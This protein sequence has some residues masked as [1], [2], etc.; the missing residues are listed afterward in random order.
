MINKLK[1]FQSVT[2]KRSPI[3]NFSE[4]YIWKLLTLTSLPKSLISRTARNLRELTSSIPSGETTLRWLKNN[5]IRKLNSSQSKKFLHFLE[6]L[7]VTFQKARKK[8]MILVLD[9]HTDPNYS[10]QTSNCIWKGKPKASTN[11][12]YRF[13]SLLWVNLLFFQV[14]FG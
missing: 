13:A 8:G 2:I 7:P 6:K 10:K 14:I 9:F 11:R 1:E 4:E 5:S 12:L 3:S